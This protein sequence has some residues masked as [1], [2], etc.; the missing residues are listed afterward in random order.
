MGARRYPPIED[1]LWSRVTKGLGCWEFQGGRNGQGYGSIGWNGVSR[2]AHRVAWALTY[3]PIPDGLDVLHH[4]DNPP[5]VRPDHLFLGTDADNVADRER[6]G[7]NKVPRGE[8]QGS[9][10]LTNAE[11]SRLRQLYYQGV[12]S[13]VLAAEFGLHRT[14]VWRIATGRSWKHLPLFD[15]AESDR[16]DREA[17]AAQP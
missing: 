13:P 5:C 11:A 8:Q 15:Q 6:K 1:R 4:C 7:R 2:R 16:L 9:A 17:A 3:G 12:P 10:K 14:V